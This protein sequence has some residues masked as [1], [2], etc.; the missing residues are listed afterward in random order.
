MGDRI[1]ITAPYIIPVFDQFQGLFDLAGLEAIIVDVEERLEEADLLR[2]AGLVDGTI[3]GDDRYTA[4]VLE[5]FSPRLRVISKWGTGIDSID[6]QAAD[7]LGIK[8]CN[9]P[10][11]FIYPVADSVLQYMLLFARRGPWMD[12]QMKSG[13]WQKEL[14]RSLFECTLGVVG[15][16]NIGKAVLRR[17][18][19]FGMVLY[20]NDIVEI[21]PDFIAEVGVEMT[22]LEN[23][24]ARSDFISIN[25]DLNPTS[26]HL[27]NG[28]SLMNAK[29]GTILINT[30]R[31]PIVDENALIEALH[32]KR[33]AGAALD[34]FEQEPLPSGSPLLK[35]ENVYLAPHNAN[36]SPTAW[37][38]V[39]QN[40]IRNLFKGLGIAPDDYLRPSKL[41]WLP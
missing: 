1:L 39:H 15:V 36:S 41:P 6:R 35:M 11:A 8:V 19:V 33:L 28:D 7:A 13:V 31:G 18:K 9:T 12:Q 10:G 24:L 23:L 21:D 14:C 38:Y 16:G 37:E 22:S 25:C 27:I 17:A 29:Q 32:S 30:A 4:A 3:C 40:T 5:K 20:G 2:Y 34:V 26:Y